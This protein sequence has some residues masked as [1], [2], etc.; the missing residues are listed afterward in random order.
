MSVGR[1]AISEGKSGLIRTNVGG[2][3][4]VS[5]RAAVPAGKPPLLFIHG[6]FAAAWCWDEFFLSWFAERGYDAHALSLR[7][8]GES[9]GGDRLDDS[10]IDDYAEDVRRVSE[11]LPAPPLLIGHSMGG[12]V[13]QKLLERQR[14][15][16][17]VLMASVPPRGLAGPGLSLAVWNPAAAVGIGAIQS[18]GDAFGSPDVM[19]EALF[20]AALGPTRALGYLSRMGPESTRAM[21][22]MYGGSLPDR[23][24]MAPCPMFVM[25]AAADELIPSTFVRAT[26]RSYD[27]PFELIDDI[28]HLMMLDVGWESVADALL[29]WM[30]R[31]GF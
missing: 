20:S 8:H 18:F 16:G 29:G 3:E 30:R 27:A 19:T 10:S 6:A 5:R 31:S 17:A 13:V 1:V 21:L 11:T 9:A 24:R 7:G 14:P 25:G 15:S 26:A 22:D 2:L 4:L 12:F 28:G 23:D